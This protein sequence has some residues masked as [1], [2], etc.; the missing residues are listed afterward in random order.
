M[1]KKY[2]F[3][4][5]GII[6]T[7]YSCQKT[8]ITPKADES[9]NSIPIHFTTTSLSAAYKTSSAISLEGA[10]DVTISGQSINGGKV[11]TIS[12]SNCYNVHITQNSLGNSTDAGIY[13]YHCHNITIDYNYITN[14]ATGVYADHPTGGA[15]VVNNNQ[16]LNMQG[17]FPRGQFVQFNTVN[18]AGNEI[19]YNKCENIL[20]KSSTQEG[21]NL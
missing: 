21:I 9:A 13:L 1:K 2:L 4:A 14:V 8:E 7:A 18:G 5:V 15:I 11:P 20:G 3:T 6:L 19:S 16:F 12:L 17:P 10:H